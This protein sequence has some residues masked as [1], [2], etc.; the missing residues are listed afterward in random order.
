MEIIRKRDRISGN[1]T[2]RIPLAGF[3]A[4]GFRVAI[5]PTDNRIGIFK[6][7]LKTY[8]IFLIKIKPLC[9]RK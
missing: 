6:N 7:Q 8:R 4:Y 3:I 1:N 5:I 2:V 9:F